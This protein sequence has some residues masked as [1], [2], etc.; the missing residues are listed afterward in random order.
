MLISRAHGIARRPDT[1]TPICPLLPSLCLLGSNGL[2]SAAR[3]LSR[4]LTT[5]PIALT[6]LIGEPMILFRRDTPFGTMVAQAC[7]QAN[8]ELESIVD[9]TRADQALALVKAPTRTRD[10]R[11]VRGARSGFDHPSADRGTRTGLDL[12]LFEVLPAL[13]QHGAPDACG[14]PAGA[15]YEPAYQQRSLPA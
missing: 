9:V 14:L 1:S 13:S 5:G 10:C 6:D 15:T 7:Q 4:P 3:S 12:C 11:R 2:P 8:V